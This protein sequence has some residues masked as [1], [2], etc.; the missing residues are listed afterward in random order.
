MSNSGPP[1]LQL[2]LDSSTTSFKRTFEDLGLELDEPSSSSTVTA[3]SQG[4]SFRHS[5]EQD[6]FSGSSSPAR[7]NKR[8]RSQDLDSEEGSSSSAGGSGTHSQHER[9]VN[10]ELRPIESISPIMDSFSLPWHN[11]PSLPINALQADN[12]TTSEDVQ[13]L[14]AESSHYD[15]TRS[16]ATMHS[17]RENPNRLQSNFSVLPFHEPE[18][19]LAQDS[20]QSQSPRS[21]GEE[22]SRSSSTTDLSS[23]TSHHTLGLPEQDFFG[24]GSLQN[25]TPPWLRDRPILPMPVAHTDISGRPSLSSLFVLPST[26]TPQSGPSGIRNFE[27]APILPI[28]RDPQEP[29]GRSDSFSTRLP[30]IPITEALSL[31]VPPAILDPL[32]SMPPLT[33][34]LQHSQS[35][36]P[37]LYSRRSSSSMGFHRSSLESLLNNNTTPQERSSNDRVESPLIP[38]PPAP[39]AGTSYRWDAMA[40]EWV[41]GQ[42]MPAPSITASPHPQAN[43]APR[44]GYLELVPSP[45]PSYSQRRW[46]RFIASPVGEDVSVG[47]SSPV[48]DFSGWPEAWQGMLGTEHFPSKST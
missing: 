14:L 48:D 1:R 7:S 22:I 2:E 25:I 18:F 43:S 40:N 42:P 36:R 38:M 20:P 3:G 30:P 44:L 34:V 4:S 39:R 9:S 24:P 11:S 21:T 35:R 23:A 29:Q 32:I 15:G 17:A 19:P 13:M 45:N 10:V 31:D 47:T 6:R 5:P 37:A 12:E 27:S 41:S 28:P 16:V 26:P 46:N 33:R 8:A